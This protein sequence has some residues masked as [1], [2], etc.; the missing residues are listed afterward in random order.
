MKLNTSYTRTSGTGSGS[1]CIVR[2]TS[3]GGGGEITGLTIIN[4]GSGYTQGNELTI[5]GG[6]WMQEHLQ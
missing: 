1:G 3:V 6:G 2:V 4:A 5:T